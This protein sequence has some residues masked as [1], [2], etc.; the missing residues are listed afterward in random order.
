VIAQFHLKIIRG[1]SEIIR[2]EPIISFNFYLL[3]YLLTY[4]LIYLLTY[5]LTIVIIF[6]LHT[7]AYLAPPDEC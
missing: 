7:F 1:N 4:L 5:L 6:L 2:V 3:T